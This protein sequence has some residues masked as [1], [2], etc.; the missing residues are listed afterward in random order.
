MSGDHES[1][2]SRYASECDLCETD[3]D[4]HMWDCP[5]NPRHARSRRSDSAP[6]QDVAS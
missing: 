4:L 1:D 2:Q 3:G 6:G 5:N